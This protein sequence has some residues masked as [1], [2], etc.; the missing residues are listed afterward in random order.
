MGRL[1]GLSLAIQTLLA[2]PGKSEIA[3]PREN[4]QAMNSL[5]SESVSEGIDGFGTVITVV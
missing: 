1:A 3:R 5:T 2:N 4:L